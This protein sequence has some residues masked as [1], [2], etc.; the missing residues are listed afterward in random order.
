VQTDGAL[1]GA[2]ASVNSEVHVE[3]TAL[4]EV[5]IAYVTLKIFYVTMSSNYMLLDIFSSG[6][7]LQADRTLIFKRLSFTLF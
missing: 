4:C 5:L 2:V 3:V 7:K 6:Q 1:V